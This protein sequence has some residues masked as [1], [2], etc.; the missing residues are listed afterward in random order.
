MRPFG[1]HAFTEQQRHHLQALSGSRAP[2]SDAS[3]GSRSVI[4]IDN[5]GRRLSTIL[6][7]ANSR[8]VIHADQTV[9]AEYITTAAP[10]LQVTFRSRR[11]V[12]N[13]CTRL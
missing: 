5:V 8:S 13:D 2:A 1:K 6:A 12:A 10:A 4:A 9:V 11:H 3:V 7:Q